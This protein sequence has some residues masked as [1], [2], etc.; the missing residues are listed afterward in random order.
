MFTSFAL[1]SSWKFSLPS[2]SIPVYRVFHRNTESPNIL[3]YKGRLDIF[4]SNPLVSFCT[5]LLPR[6]PTRNSAGTVL[7]CK[8]LVLLNFRRFQSAHSFLLFRFSW[9]FP[10]GCFSIQ[11]AVYKRMRE[12]FGYLLLSYRQFERDTADNNKN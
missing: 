3:V 4:E 2:S 11:S 6:Q 9:S 1:H 7:S 10:E 5:E 8:T 12:I